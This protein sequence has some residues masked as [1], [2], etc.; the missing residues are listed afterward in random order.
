[1]KSFLLSMIVLALTAGAAHAGDAETVQ[2][3]VTGFYRWYVHLLNANPRAE[4]RNKP[5][6]HRYVSERLLKETARQAKSPDGLEADPF[7]LSQDW[8][9][10]WEEK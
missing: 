3:Q 5:E 4:P 6:I 2:A 10:A 8:D 1:M 9:P 7:M